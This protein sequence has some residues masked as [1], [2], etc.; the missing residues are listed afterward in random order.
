M[1]L[2]LKTKFFFFI[3][4]EEIVQVWLCLPGPSLICTYINEA[5]TISFLLP[6]HLRVS[7][8]DPDIGDTSV[9][10]NISY[11]LDLTNQVIG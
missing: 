3:F 11:S 2:F 4:F 6:P 7:A 9:P 10:Q 1:R 5:L 8:I